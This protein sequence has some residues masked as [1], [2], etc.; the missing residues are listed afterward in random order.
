MPV[1]VSDASVLICLGAV[2]LLDLL[3]TLYAEIVV[4]NA[5]LQEVLVAASSRPGAQETAQAIQDGWIKVQKP[6]NAALVTSLQATL[7]SGEAEAIALASE[8]HAALILMDE[9]A[10]RSVVKRLGM[11]VVGT[12]GV[13]LRAKQTGALPALK[14]VL[15]R[16]MNQYR[17]RLSRKL[18]DD[19]LREVGEI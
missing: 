7:D 1:V 2:N 18:Y 5:V 3:K 13:L 12:L 8:L 6:S 10:G 11:R 15:D 9:S 16:L 4:P 14:P 19:A 17:F